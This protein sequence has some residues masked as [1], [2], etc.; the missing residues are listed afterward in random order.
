M[1]TPGHIWHVA[2]WETFRDRTEER[3]YR[4]PQRAARQVLSILSAPDDVVELRELAVTDGWERES[5]SWQ[6]L[7]PREFVVA[8]LAGVTVSEVE[9]VEDLPVLEQFALIEAAWIAAQERAAGGGPGSPVAPTPGETGTD[10]GLS[11]PAQASAAPPSAAAPPICPTT[12]LR[13]P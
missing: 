9:G 4:S 8:S 12:T 6:T 7:D 3:R 2:W 1:S 13:K 10:V 11:L 5:L